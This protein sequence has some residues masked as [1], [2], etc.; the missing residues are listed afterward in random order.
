MGGTPTQ[1]LVNDG[2]Y[3][4]PRTW[5]MM[6]GTFHLEQGNDGRY[7]PPRTQE[8]LELFRLVVNKYLIKDNVSP[9][10]EDGHE[11]KIKVLTNKKIPLLN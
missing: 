5:A 8:K 7:T 6:G 1:H 4:P 3:I 10:K 2:R 9:V 11:Y